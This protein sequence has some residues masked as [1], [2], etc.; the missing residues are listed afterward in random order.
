MSFEVVSDVFWTHLDSVKL[1]NAFHIV[2]LMDITYKT[3]KYMLSMLEIIGVTSTR[4][5]FSVA[6]VLLSNKRENNFVWALEKL[7][8]LLLTNDVHLL[9]IICDR[10][11]TLINTINI[12]FPQGACYVDFHQ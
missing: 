2:L 1:L 7:K 8:G 12:I 5:T 6:C 10:D 11:L 9:V 3:N 4:L